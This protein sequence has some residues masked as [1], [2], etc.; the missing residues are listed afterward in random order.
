[1][2]DIV[3][4]LFVRNGSVLLARRSP[5]RRA[6]PSVWSFPGGHVDQ[7]E[8]LEQTLVRE[9]REEVAVVPQTYNL[10]AVISDPNAAAA[11]PIAYHMFVVTGWEGGEPTIVDDEHT[12]LTWFAF[13]AAAALPDLALDQYRSLFGKLAGA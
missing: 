8:S 5:R 1:M 7:G 10:F 6:Y 4:A 13:E 9:L 2:R 12:E 11:D 3:N